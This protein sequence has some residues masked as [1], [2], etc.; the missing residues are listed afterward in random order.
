MQ[1]KEKIVPAFEAAHPNGEQMLLMVDNSQGHSC[2][3]LDALLTKR[4][5]LSSGGKQAIMRDG[6]YMKNGERVTQSM[7]FPADHEEYPNGAKGIRQ[8]LEERG[9][10]RDRLLLQCKKQKDPALVTCG[11]D[12]NDCCARQLLSSQPDF[13]EQRSAVQEAVEE[14]GHI[15]IVL[16][17]FHCE[18]NFIEHF[19]CDVKRY[20]RTNCDFTWETLRDN[21]PLALASVPLER[22]RKYEHRMHRWLEAYEKGMDAKAAQTE[23]KKYSSRIYTSHRRIP[24]AVNVA[25]DA[26]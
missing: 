21:M 4:M 23:V 14:A 16:P 1:I 18:L 6:W 22:I 17:K 9:L 26:E 15:C 20:L 10:W 11:V 7:V 8:V 3:A 5:N 2:Y 19:W 13:F 24:E 25:L 12:S